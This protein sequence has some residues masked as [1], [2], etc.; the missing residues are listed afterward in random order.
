[1]LFVIIEAGFERFF[2]LLGKKYVQPI[3]SFDFSK[4]QIAS[5]RLR[6]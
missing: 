3:L 4:V 5:K 1:M 2:K 6:K